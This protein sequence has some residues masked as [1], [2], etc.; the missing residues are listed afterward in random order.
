MNFTEQLLQQFLQQHSDA[1]AGKLEFSELNKLFG[2]FQQ[3]INNTARTAFDGLSPEQMHLLLYAPLENA[4]PLRLKEDIDIAV[5]EVP[6][7]QLS[8][9][10]LNEI[11]RT[12]KLKLTQK[13]NLPIRV[14]ELLY[15]KQLIDW[16]Y[17]AYIKQV[18]EETI[19]YIS[20]LKF[21]LLNWA[22]KKST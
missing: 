2:S 15:A 7:F 11:N 8:E 6:I 3:N 19:P 16:K 5:Q 14:C 10:L 17:A 20:I 4:C 21:Y 13:G 22:G 9:H 12:G 1:A 18:S